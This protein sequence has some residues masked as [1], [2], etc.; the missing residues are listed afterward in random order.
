MI[1]PLLKERKCH[2]DPVSPCST[3]RTRSDYDNKQG[4][5][6]AEYDHD[7]TFEFEENEDPDYDDDPDNTNHDTNNHDDHS[8]NNTSINEEEGATMTDTTEEIVLDNDPQFTTTTAT[9]TL[10]RRSRR[11]QQ[12]PKQYEPN[13][14]GKSYGMQLFNLGTR[15]ILEQTKGNVDIRKHT[16]NVIFTQMTADKG[17]KEFGEVAVA[18]IFKEYK[19]MQELNVLGSLDPDKLTPEEKCSAL[20][21]VNLIKLKRCGKVKGRM[22]ANGAPHR[23]FIPREEAKSPT[24]SQ[25]G[26][27]CM[28]IIAAHERRKVGSFDVPGAYLQADVPSDKFRILKLDGK[29]VDIMCEVNLEYKQYGRLENGRKVLYLR[30]LKA[31]YGMIESAL[32][33]YQ[34]YVEVL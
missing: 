10:P 7:S 2:P 31:L 9:S 23:N 21:A 14:N 33:W 12:T 5:Y 30:I 20:R 27:L 25:D 22:C 32:L 24:V 8:Q 4:A 17:I 34:L 13:F 19:Q 26:L 6:D 18:A 16:F 11:E 1:K 28:A 3:R 15:Q 29:Y